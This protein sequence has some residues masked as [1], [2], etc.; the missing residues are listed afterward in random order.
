[1]EGYND[2]DD[3]LE[4]VPCPDGAC[5]GTLDAD[6][7]CRY[8]GVLGDAPPRLVTDDSGDEDGDEDD[9]EDDEDS[10]AAAS[11]G[12]DDGDGDD[13]LDDPWEDRQLCP[14]GSCTGS[15]GEDGRCRVCGL[16]AA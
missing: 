7:R 2:D 15:V 10:D 8:C 5:I 6:G 11:D 12:S 3:T 16:E 9:D 1:M 4:R 13:A 14:D